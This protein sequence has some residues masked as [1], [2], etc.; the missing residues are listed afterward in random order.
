MQWHSMTPI[1]SRT[2][3]LCSYCYFSLSLVRVTI[4]L[5]VGTTCSNI[6]LFWNVNLICREG[7]HALYPVCIGE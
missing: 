5:T 1:A 2:L 7:I 6:S 4:K 3:K